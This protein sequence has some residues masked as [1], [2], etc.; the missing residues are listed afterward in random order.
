MK[1]NKKMVLLYIIIAILLLAVI[2]L[3]VLLFLSRRNQSSNETA[4]TSTDSSSADFTESTLNSDAV[5][6]TS[7]SGGSASDSDNEIAVDPA[8][9]AT[10][11][12]EITSK[13]E[14]LV[15]AQIAV[16]ATWESDETPCASESVTIYNNSDQPVSDWSLCLTFSSTPIILELWNGLYT[17]EGNTVTITA[18]SYNTEISAGESI[19]LGYNIMTDDVVPLSWCILSGSTQIGSSDSQSSSL[20]SVQDTDPAE[21]K[22][23]VTSNETDKPSDSTES[24]EVETQTSSQSAAAANESSPYAVH[25]KLAVTSSGIVDEHGDAFQLK[26][27][28]THGITWFPEYVNLDT[29]RYL[30][31]NWDANVIRLAMYTDTGDAYGYCSGGDK[32]EIEAL[33]DTGVSAATELGMY[34]I[35][36][37]HILNDGN[38][39]TYLAE[40]KS[41]FEKMSKKY[42]G[43]GNVIYEIANE[44]NSGTTWAEVKSYA[45]EIIGIIRAYAPDAVIIVG[46]PTWCQDIDSAAADPLDQFSNIIYSVHFYAGTHKE[47]LRSK[48]QAAI[49]AGLPVII[50]EFG[51]CDASGSGAI[52]YEQSDAWFDLIG[53]YNLS[54]VGWNL[55]NK[56]ETS[57]L[58]SSSCSKI[59]GFSDS[60]LS[61]SGRYLKGKMTD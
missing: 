15:Y 20:S 53:K 45:E 8:E 25:G 50:S 28:S 12:T 54:Y 60:E 48:I 2:F 47:T 58:I 37:W 14:N 56:A 61:D 46:T 55:S 18:E 3:S 57:S 38:P 42:A 35:I 10:N 17:I 23:E 13:D 24:E 5:S 34:V 9:T 22:T 6:E 26:G 7:S 59:S 41:F 33:I 30:E 49:E 1:E 43:Y 16:N 27:V 40:A 21:I 4:G 11:E 39:N 32:D 31:E 36:D 52:D 51:L 29:F 44:P 19:E